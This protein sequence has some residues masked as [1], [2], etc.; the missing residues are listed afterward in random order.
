MTN[1]SSPV[2]EHPHVPAAFI[3][4]IADEGTKAEAIESLQKQWNENCALRAELKA[5]RAPAQTQPTPSE[6]ELVKTEIARA[7]EQDT[8]IS[9]SE[10]EFMDELRR[11]RAQCA[12]MREALELIRKQVIERGGFTIERGSGAMTVI[13][14]ALS[15]VTSTEAHAQTPDLARITDL[16]IF[17]HGG[18]RATVD[19]VGGW[20]STQL[21][22]IQNATENAKKLNTTT[23]T[24]TDDKARCNHWPGQDRCGVCGMDNTAVTRPE[25]KEG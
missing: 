18:F 24:S 25:S 22:A 15:S 9:A 20:G 14:N 5:L 21:A 8:A 2:K 19:G 7:N 13:A 23:V 4:A 3:N 6:A 10:V 1:H 12:P 17:E 16:R 11:R